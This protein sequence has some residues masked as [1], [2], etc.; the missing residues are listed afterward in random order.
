MQKSARKPWDI[1]IDLTYKPAISILIP[2]Y[3]EGPVIQYKLQNLAR[4]EYP[5][6]LMQLIIVDSASDDDTIEKIQVFKQQNPSILILLIQESERKG[7]SSALNVAL[8]HASGDVVIVSDADCFWSNDILAKALPYLA[9]P[10]VGAVAG[11][12]KLLNPHQSW[13]TKTESLYRDRMFNIQLGESKF[14]STVQFEGGFGA[15]NRKALDGFDTETGS[16]DSGT[17]LNLVN[18]GF[19]TLVLPEALFYTFFPPTWKGKI[20]IK[21]RR[22]Q[23]FFWI[24]LK[25]FKSM[26]S[27]DLSLPKRIFLPPAFFLLIN[28]FIFILFI[29]STLLLLF[30]FPYLALLPLALILIPKTRVY[31]VELFQNNLVALLATIEGITGKQAIIWTKA[32]ESRKNFDAEVLKKHGLIN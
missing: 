31:L 13:V 6:N 2:T 29:S 27:H 11:Q 30:Q 3:N 21:T 18:K 5:K 17:A 22:A 7:K 14:Y 4:L 1:K 28:P 25:C 19:R 10:K 23:Q 20:T 12:E 24:H 26:L 15:Y 16:D 9:D 32:V 8:E